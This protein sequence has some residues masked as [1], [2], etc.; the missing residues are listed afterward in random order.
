MAFHGACPTGMSMLDY[1]ICRPY[2]SHY[3][4]VNLFAMGVAN[5]RACELEIITG[6]G[7]NMAY[8]LGDFRNFD[9]FSTAVKE[10]AQESS[11]KC[12]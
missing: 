2:V 5:A 7:T 9:R 1:F 4:G 10:I 6:K 3:L 8:G 12:A 11:D